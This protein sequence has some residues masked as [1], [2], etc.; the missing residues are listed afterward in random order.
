MESMG[1]SV[2]Y[3]DYDEVSFPVNEIGSICSQSLLFKQVRW[4]EIEWFMFIWKHWSFLQ[5]T[6]YS[7]IISVLSHTV[8]KPFSSCDIFVQNLISRNLWTHVLYRLFT[9]WTPSVHI[10]SHLFLML[11]DVHPVLS[12]SYHRDAWFWFHALIYN[13]TFCWVFLL[14]CY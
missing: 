5:N 10:A 8:H 13:F 3:R 7:C 6:G 1:P 14:F 9:L 12:S 2:I 4:Y 11:A